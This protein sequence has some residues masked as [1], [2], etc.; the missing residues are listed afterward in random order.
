MPCVSKNVRCV[1]FN[2]LKHF[3]PIFVFLTHNN[4]IFLDFKSSRMSHLTL[5]LL[6]HYPIIH[7]QPNRR[8][9]FL[10]GLLWLLPDDRRIPVFLEISS[11]DWCICD[12]PSWLNTRSPTRPHSPPLPWM[13]VNWTDVF[14]S[15]RILHSFQFAT[16]NFF[17]QRLCS[18]SFK[19]TN[20]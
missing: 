15:L 6:P 1:F 3:E 4:L 12:A 10:R 13:P 14:S 7:W 17:Q 11:T 5:V 2:N 16:W 19:E 18:V 20:I 9:V 8:I